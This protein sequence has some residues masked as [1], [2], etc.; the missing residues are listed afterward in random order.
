M[1]DE[2]GDLKL[3]QVER[4]RKKH[5][6]TMFEEVGFS[7]MISYYVWWIIYMNFYLI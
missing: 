5:C 3:K 4:K 1:R 7:H 6:T 2:D